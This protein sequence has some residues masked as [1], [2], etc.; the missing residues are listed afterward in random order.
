MAVFGAFG[1]SVDIYPIDGMTNGINKFECQSS[2]IPFI[3]IVDAEPS[4][5][6][7]IC[8][9]IYEVHLV[10]VT[11]NN[12]FVTLAMTSAWMDLEVKANLAYTSRS[13]QGLQRCPWNPLPWTR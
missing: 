2:L 1:L 4:L 12:L 13:I 10:K 7:I 8:G 3:V 5:Q 6:A 9:T 11:C